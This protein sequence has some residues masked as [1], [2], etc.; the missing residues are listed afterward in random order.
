VGGRCQQ[1]TID[2]D[3]FLVAALELLDGSLDV[4]HAALDA[5]L[6]GGEV[7]VETSTVP[8]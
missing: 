8:V 7:A 5:H 1:R 6:L 2:G 3:V 4:L